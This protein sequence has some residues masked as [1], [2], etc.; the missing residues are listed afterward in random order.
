[1]K[2]LLAIFLA[3]VIFLQPLYKGFIYV[4]FKI[5]QDTIARTVCVKKEIKNNTCQGKC[6]LKKELNKA[7][8]KEQKQAP[9]AQ[10]EKFEVLFNNS[11][12]NFSFIE[13]VALYSSKLNDYSR[14]NLYC[15]SF[16]NSIFQPP[17]I[18]LI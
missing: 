15:F 5:N 1:M 2:Y 18:N 12:R 13:K 16:L 8:Q 14:D 7:D 6:H 11:L 10:K 3:L 9:N 4:S 17:Q